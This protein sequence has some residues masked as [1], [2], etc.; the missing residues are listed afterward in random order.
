MKLP[1]TKKNELAALYFPGAAPKVATRHLMRWINGCPPLN[2]E[3]RAAGYSPLQKI[4]TAR[5][6]A[7]IYNHLGDPD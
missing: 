2:E 1:A 4:F 6:T 3:L 7:L 5:Q